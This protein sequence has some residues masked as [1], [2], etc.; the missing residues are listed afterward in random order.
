MAKDGTQRGGQRV[1][2][3]RKPSKKN[4]I[5]QPKLEVTDLP[6]PEMIEGVD[7]PPAKEFMKREQK[8]GMPL[9]AMEVYKDTYKWLKDRNCEGLVNS[10][11]VEQYA[12]SV[13]RWIQCEEFISTYGQLAKHPTTGNASTSPYVSMGQNYMKQIN[14]TWYQIYAIVRD[15]NAQGIS[16]YSPQD[17][18]MERL[19]R[20]KNS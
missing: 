8:A 20:S 14:Q 6:K 3:G 9:C 17:D 19:L 7:M 5:E 12:M 18:M 10:N 11:L 4:T 16:E 13:A 1:G 2:S 15:N